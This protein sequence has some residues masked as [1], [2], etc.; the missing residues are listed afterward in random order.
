MFNVYAQHGPGP[1]IIMPQEKT[2]EGV[3]RLAEAAAQLGNDV[4]YRVFEV[5]SESVSGERFK[6]AF[7][8]LDGTVRE[9][10]SVTIPTAHW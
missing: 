8:V 6:T 3:R 10:R 1:M 4:L 5:T 9:H 7:S 2:I